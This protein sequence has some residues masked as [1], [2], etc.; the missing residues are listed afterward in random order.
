MSLKLIIL[1]CTYSGLLSLS[2]LLFFLIDLI[3]VEVFE[4]S[5]LI[6]TIFIIGLCLNRNMATTADYLTFIEYIQHQPSF[7]TLHEATSPFSIFSL[8]NFA[9]NFFSSLINFVKQFPLLF[10]S[11]F[12]SPSSLFVASQLEN[13]FHQKYGDKFQDV[14]SNHFSV[15][16]PSGKH[17]SFSTLGR[18]LTSVIHQCG[19]GRSFIQAHSFSFVSY[20][21]R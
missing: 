7:S 3:L 17:V 20:P 16:S 14:T 5:Q 15:P 11:I 10:N 19:T 6:Y 4:F 18:T 21:Q 13:L 2:F 8:L 9:S 1:F 12:N